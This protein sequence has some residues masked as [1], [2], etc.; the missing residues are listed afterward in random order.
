MGCPYHDGED[1][2]EVD[3]DRSAGPNGSANRGI[4]RRSF[5]K[6]ALVIGGT[7][8]LEPTL[9]GGGVALVSPR[10]PPDSGRT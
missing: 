7:S 8:G 3:P 5:M 9:L 10:E 6:S 4:E 1:R 2:D